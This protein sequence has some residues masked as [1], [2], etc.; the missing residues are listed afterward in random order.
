MLAKNKWIKIRC[1]LAGPYVDIVCLGVLM[2]GLLVVADSH[3]LTYA[4]R[5]ALVI[6]LM[7]FI[8]NLNPWRQSDG[9][10]ALSY[11]FSDPLIMGKA[12]YRAKSTQADT[13]AMRYYQAFAWIYLTA[14]VMLLASLVWQSYLLVESIIV[15]Y[16]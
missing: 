5:T 4:L 9:M 1:A 16:A 11:Y 8:L 6:V 14:M 12:L 2:A 13:R 3:L 7:G 15:N 10:I